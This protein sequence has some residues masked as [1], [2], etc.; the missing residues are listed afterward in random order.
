MP[1]KKVYLK[2]SHNSQESA[3]ARESFYVKLQQYLD[4]S[5]LFPFIWIL[6]LPAF[7]Q[8]SGLLEN[9]YNARKRFEE[10]YLPL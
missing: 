6:V 2:I 5:K 7:L 8:F 10:N 4:W 1:C 3:C 9:W